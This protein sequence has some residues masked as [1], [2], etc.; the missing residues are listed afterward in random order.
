VVDVAGVASAVAGGK[1]W[2]LSFSAAS[3]GGSY[4]AKRHE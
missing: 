1:L 4:N 3:D 2:L